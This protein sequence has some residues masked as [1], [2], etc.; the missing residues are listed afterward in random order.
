[1]REAQAKPN[2]RRRLAQSSGIDVASQ[3]KER[4]IDADDD[5]AR[6]VAAGPPAKVA[7][8]RAGR[9]APY[10]RRALG[11]EAVAAAA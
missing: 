8:S 5:G 4:V 9:T 6:I 11:E 1:M 7:S 2:R 10:R 3:S